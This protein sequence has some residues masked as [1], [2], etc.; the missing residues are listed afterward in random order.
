MPTPPM[1]NMADPRPKSHTMG[2]TPPY[3]MSLPALQGTT[4]VLLEPETFLLFFAL[5]PYLDIWIDS[6]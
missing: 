5:S 1:P 2:C 6:S 4:V 3:M